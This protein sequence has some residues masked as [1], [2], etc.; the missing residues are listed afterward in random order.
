MLID[1]K[2]LVDSGDLLAWEP[3]LP[4][5]PSVRCLFVTRDIMGELDQNT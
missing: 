3:S 1:V 4:G 5:A 2:T